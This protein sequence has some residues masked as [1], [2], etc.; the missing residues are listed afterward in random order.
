[1][2]TY[3]FC[4]PSSCG[5]RSIPGL[6]S[7]NKSLC[8]EEYPPFAVNETTTCWQ[9]KRGEKINQEIWPCGNSE[10]YRIFEPGNQGGSK[11]HKTFLMP[12]LTLLVFAISLCCSGYYVMFKC[13]G[14]YKAKAP[15]EEQAA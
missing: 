15:E 5:H 14:C 13:C 7:K 4:T 11:E 10:C 2:G 3:I 8:G 6:N 1:M 9:P 12:I